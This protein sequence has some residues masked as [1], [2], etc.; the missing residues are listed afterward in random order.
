M[1]DAASS[2]PSLKARNRAT[3]WGLIVFDG[4]LLCIFLFG[5]PIK[6]LSLDNDSLLMMLLA[7]SVG[8]LIAGFL[9][10]LVSSDVKAIFV[11]WRFKYVLPGHQAFSV[12]VHADPRIDIKNLKASIGVFPSD[13]KDQNQL[14]YSLYRK[15]EGDV[16]VEDSHRNFLLYRDCASLTLLVGVVVAICTL[17]FELDTWQVAVLAAGMLLQYGICVI[18]AQNSGKRF[19]QNVLAAASLRANR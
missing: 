7:S 15:H 2:R 14:W 9:N 3:I 16:R 18:A 12:L 8:P 5:L 10:G 17:V 6:S 11:F 1:G 19:V 13:P 4:L